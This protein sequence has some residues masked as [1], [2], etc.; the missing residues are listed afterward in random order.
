MHLSVT[1]VKILKSIAAAVA[2]LQRKSLQRTREPTPESSTEEEDDYS[3]QQEDKDTQT[4]SADEEQEYEEETRKEMKKRRR[5]KR[6]KVWRR[7]KKRNKERRRKQKWRRKNKRGVGKIGVMSFA[8][9]FQKAVV[10][11]KVRLRGCFNNTKIDKTLRLFI[12]LIKLSSCKI[13]V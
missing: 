4:S 13:F 10:K 1:A 8:S 2:E 9:I 7:K 6:K 3:E 5:W 12:F 11:L